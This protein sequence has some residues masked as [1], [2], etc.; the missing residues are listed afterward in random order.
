[1]R[2]ESID[3]GPPL[4][5]ISSS[6]HLTPVEARKGEGQNMPIMEMKGAQRYQSSATAVMCLRHR[7]RSRPTK[8]VLLSRQEWRDDGHPSGNVGHAGSCVQWRRAAPW[9]GA[10]R[11]HGWLL[12]EA[13]DVLEPN[14]SSKQTEILLNGFM[15]VRLAVPA[16][17]H[18]RCACVTAAP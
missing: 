1:M 2:R 7:Y 12:G 5:D 13:T 6:G 16:R 3:Q 11:N 14:T 17:I 10:Q 4:F 18:Y 8:L 9:V 15:P